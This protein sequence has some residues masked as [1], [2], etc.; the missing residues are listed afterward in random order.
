M[1]SD[2]PTGDDFLPPV[3]G[4]GPAASDPKYPYVPGGGRQSTIVADL[5]NRY[6]DWVKP[7]RSE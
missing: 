2:W 4:A 5:T 7:M 3:T 1:D 6:Q